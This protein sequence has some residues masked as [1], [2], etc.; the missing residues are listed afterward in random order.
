MAGITEGGGGILYGKHPSF[1]V[2]APDGWMFDNESGIPQK[3]FAVMYPK[4][5]TWHDSDVVVYVQTRPLDNKVK[6]AADA[7]ADTVEE[8]KENGSP[9]CRAK[10]SGSIKLVN[11]KEAAVYHFTG[12]KWGNFEAAAYFLEEGWIHY[13]VLNAKSEA[14]FK[15]S[16]PAFDAM[17]KSYTFIGETKNQGNEEDG[18][19]DKTENTPENGKNAPAIKAGKKNEPSEPP[20]E[21]K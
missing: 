1:I 5:K 9:D 11:G 15:A 14:V 6:S 17:V 18:E 7:A 3:L 13:L 16:L 8:F 20:G 19:D 10:A 21:S 12:D 4:G 2:S